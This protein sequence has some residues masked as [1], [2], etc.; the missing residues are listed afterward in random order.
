[1]EVKSKVEK[2]DPLVEAA[3]QRLPVHP[4]PLRGPELL[5]EVRNEP[6]DLHGVH[7]ASVSITYR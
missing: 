5:L 1:M 4:A 7:D 3:L 2:S 6:F